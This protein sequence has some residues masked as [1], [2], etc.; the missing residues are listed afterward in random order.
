MHERDIVFPCKVMFNSLH[1]SVQKYYT[2][3]YANT[4]YTFARVNSQ[5]KSVTAWDKR[6]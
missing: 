6:D 4:G 3:H 5:V 1:K 2:W